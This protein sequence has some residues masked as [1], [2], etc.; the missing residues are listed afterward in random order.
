MFLRKLRIIVAG[1]ALIA[2]PAAAQAATGS[3]LKVGYEISLG[4]LSFG[5]I[6][7]EAQL[8]DEA[9][10][11]DALLETKGL[12]DI[13]FHSV[14]K[15]ASQGAF[16]GEHVRP[17]R[18][19]SDFSNKNSARTVEL[20]YGPN[21]DPRM[22]AEPPYED[23]FGAGISARARRGTQD[24]VSALLV[25]MSAGALQPCN[26]SLPVFDGRRRYNIQLTY[27]AD[28]LMT[29]GPESYTGKAVR[30]RVK[31]V[32]VAGYERKKFL[33]MLRTNDDI[34]IWLAPIR[35]GQLYVPV[36]LSFRTPFGG[37]VARATRFIVSD[38]Q[39]AAA[40]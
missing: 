8:D 25:P 26:R 6:Q 22:T 23:G 37:A 10:D 15:L 24:P 20:I 32:P 16:A 34:R 33:E 18:F 14:F 39:R 36:R 11:L 35:G 30:C 17:A 27:D 38:P 19:L 3:S 28:T 12:A 40:K 7:L 4:G 5:E 9:Y 1:V 29:G 13:F 21:G 2:A 31:F